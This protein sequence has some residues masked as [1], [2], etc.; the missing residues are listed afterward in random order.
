[1]KNKIVT[2]GEVL[3]RVSKAGCRRFTQGKSFIGTFG[4][5]EANVA[6]SLAILGDDVEYVT[7]LP[8]NEMAQACIMD[9][10][11]YGVDLSHLCRGGK[12]LGLYYF[13]E[14][15]CTRN[16]LVVYDRDDSSFMQLEPGMID[17]PTIFQTAHHFHWSGIACALSEGAAAAT[18]EAILTA[19]NMG[20]TVSC[21]INYRKNL[22]NYGKKAEDVLR[23]LVEQSD[24]IF[25]DTK[26][27]ALIS[28]RPTPAFDA[29]DPSYSLDKASYEAWGAELAKQFPRC[30]HFLMAMRNELS[31]NHHILSGVLYAENRLYTTSIKDLDGVV[32]P[33][34]TGDAFIAA[35]LHAHYAHPG[36]HLYNLN[37]SL[38]ASGLKNSFDGDFNLATEEE[39]RNYMNH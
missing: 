36:Q 38:A 10:R 5:S 16:S 13:E 28:G 21:D 22:W 20:L 39:I 25:G 37:Y 12:R 9:L 17:W 1:M 7:R 6:V 24:I 18:R 33:M 30:R 32:D 14:A 26:E 2:F 23:P 35:Y 34:G 19:R 31:T 4:G 3:L 15:S 11:S 27:F 8:L 29:H